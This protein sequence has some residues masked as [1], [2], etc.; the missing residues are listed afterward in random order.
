DAMLGTALQLLGWRPLLDGEDNASELLPTRLRHVGDSVFID[1]VTAAGRL[2]LELWRPD[3][4]ADA[5]SALATLQ[6]AP[7]CLS[8]SL[9]RHLIERR[10]LDV[11]P[12]PAQMEIAAGVQL[13]NR[14]RARR[15]Y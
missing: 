13:L 3:G 5:K 1:S 10:A 6:T 9:A 15:F 8:I 7:A 14:L 2:I 4:T 12:L 11:E